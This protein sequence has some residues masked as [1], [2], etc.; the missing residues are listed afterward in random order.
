MLIKKIVIKSM[1]SKPMAVIVMPFIGEIL[2]LNGSVFLTGLF[3]FY[4]SLFTIHLFY[5]G[6]VWGVY[7][8]WDLN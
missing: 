5:G 1:G 6:G 7:S 4:N 2:D 3:T 8:F